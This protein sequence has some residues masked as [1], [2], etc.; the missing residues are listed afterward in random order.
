MRFIEGQTLA[1]AIV[2]YHSGPPDP[3]VFRRLLQSFLQVCQTVAYAHSRGVIH[4]DLKPQNVMLG[5]FGETL[6]VD[7]GL[8]KVVGRPEEVRAERVAEETLVPGSGSGGNETAMGSAVGTPAYMSPEQAAGRWD[9]I[10]QR[11]DV[12]GLGA[13]LYTLLTGKPP[14]GKGNWPEM[15]QKIQR[16][17][18][19]RPRQVKPNVPRALEAV[20]LRAMALDPATRYP[21]AAAVAADVEH[22]L[23]EEPVAAYREPLAAR[24]GRWLRR[25]RS[26]MT[27]AAVLLV[28]AL[29][30]AGAGLVLLGQKNREVASE[31]NAARA[32]ADEAEAVNAFLTDDL[33]GQADPDQNSWDKRVTVE[34]V[35]AKAARKIDGNAKFADKPEIEATLRVAIGKSYYKLG[36]SGEAVRHLRHATDLRRGCLPTD[37]PRTLAA[38]N[39]LAESLLRGQENLAEAEPLALQTWEARKRVLGP[40]HRDTLDSLDIYASALQQRGHMDE[41]LVLMRECLDARRAAF[42]AEDAD[43]LSSMNN[44]AVILLQR[45]EWKEA[46]RLFREAVAI[47]ERKG[48]GLDSFP[49]VANLGHCLYFLGDLDAADEILARYSD[50][51]ARQFGP[52][53]KVTH[54][55]RS[56]QARVWVENRK[57]GQAVE[58]LNEV[59]AAR[60]KNVPG[61][62][63]RTASYLVDFGRA[64][65]ALGQPGEAAV[66]LEQARQMYRTSPPLYGYYTPWADACQGMALLA[67]GKHADAEPLLL[68]AEQR[69]RGLAVCPRR[70][71]RQVVESLCNL[72]EAWKKPTDAARWRNELERFR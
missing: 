72:Y 49:L 52:D 34:E 40:V 32:A 9:V 19:P 26:L 66:T 25:H 71:Y 35:L 39:A 43:T 48:V 63:W 44:V 14:L 70:H 27:A 62:D 24:G 11:S 20:C 58:A 8:A 64:K 2:A 3:L 46:S 55:L 28:T 13:M 30:A 54:F 4:R 7:W 42:G 1:T 41:G 38:Q 50:R 67:L 61:G 47:Q 37:D 10:D 6:V 18:F 69:L 36:N 65:L 22:W 31:R 60:R 68:S 33:L 16:G 23:A 17:D 56:Y 51:A 29:T 57:A 12:Y 45:G 53:H 15:Q 5:K 59:I 21:S